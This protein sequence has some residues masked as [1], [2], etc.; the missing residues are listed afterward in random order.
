M[1]FLLTEDDLEIEGVQCSG[2]AD[3]L[4][5]PRCYELKTSARIKAGRYVESAQRLA[6]LVRY[7]VPLTMILAQVK[8]TN[9]RGRPKD[10]KG[11][12]TLEH[13]TAYPI[14]PD[15]TDLGRLQSLIRNCLTYLRTDAAMI[16]HVQNKKPP[17]LL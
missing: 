9:P 14:D 15:P 16:D 5:R 3:Y 12:V 4:S 6:Y 2:R 17:V 10:I 7:C 8:I 1:P 11:L 13:C